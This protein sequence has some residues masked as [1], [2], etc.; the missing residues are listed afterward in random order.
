MHTCMH[1]QYL[2]LTSNPA[3]PFGLSLST[4]KIGVFVDTECNDLKYEKKR[5][6]KQ[7]LHPMNGLVTMMQVFEEFA[8]KHMESFSH[9]IFLGYS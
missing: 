5:K 6:K 8:Q 2:V 4:R 7:G 1:S 9:F 3:V